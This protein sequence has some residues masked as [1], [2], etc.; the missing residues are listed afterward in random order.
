[1]EGVSLQPA[2][3]GRSLK[4]PQPI[5]WEHESNRAVRDG[6]WKLVSKA[7][8][9]WE[10]YDMEQDRTEMHDLSSKYPEKVSEL[11]AA[12][13]SWAKRANVLPLGAWKEDVKRTRRPK[14]NAP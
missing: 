12:W 3:L 14:G 9:P 6:K 2:L 7:E 11:S 13:D 1:M 8:Q 10:L 5:F 4:R